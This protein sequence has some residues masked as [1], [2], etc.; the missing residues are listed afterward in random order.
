VHLHVIYVVIFL[1]CS[2]NN[3]PPR[4]LQLHRYPK[5]PL[6]AIVVITVHTITGAR[7]HTSRP[8]PSRRHQP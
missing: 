3:V 1:L 5:P 7:T 2:A 8:V 6:H 4:H